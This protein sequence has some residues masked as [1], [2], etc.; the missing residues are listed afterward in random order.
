LRDLVDNPRFL[1]RPR[2][3]QELGLDDAELAGIEP[4]EAANRRDLAFQHRISSI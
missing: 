3:V 4:A 2:A 1:Q